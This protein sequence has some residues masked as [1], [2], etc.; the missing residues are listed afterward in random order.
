MVTRHFSA[1]EASLPS[2]FPSKKMATATPPSND[3]LELLEG[4][5]DAEDGEEDILFEVGQ[6][7]PVLVRAHS[8][9]LKKLG[10]DFFRRLLESPMREGREGRVKLPQWEGEVFCMFKRFIYCRKLNVDE[11]KAV[12]ARPDAALGRTLSQL[13]DIAEACLLGDAFR[14]YLARPEM[15]KYVKELFDEAAARRTSD[16]ETVAW[17]RS[18]WVSLGAGPMSRYLKD[19]AVHVEA[20]LIKRLQWGNNVFPLMCFATEH[21]MPLLREKCLQ[22]TKWEVIETTNQQGAETQCLQKFEDEFALERVLRGTQSNGISSR[23]RLRS[24]AECVAVLIDG[25]VDFTWN[26]R[27]LLK[28]CLSERVVS[29]VQG[30]SEDF[31]RDRAR[32]EEVQSKLE[33]ADSKASVLQMKVDAAEG[34]LEAVFTLLAENNPPSGGALGGP[35]DLNNKE[36][37]TKVPEG[38]SGEEKPGAS[39]SGSPRLDVVPG[40]TSSLNL[41]P[42]LASEVAQKALVLREDRKVAKSQKEKIVRL[43]AELTAAK[44]QIQDL[45]RQRAELEQD[46]DRGSL[47]GQQ[48]T[49]EVAL[50]TDQADGSGSRHHVDQRC[51]LARVWPL[52]WRDRGGGGSIGQRGRAENRS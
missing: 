26:R 36:T 31:D 22:K 2:P 48:Q 24:F 52:R 20:M 3:C 8:F 51:W 34:K 12:S 29:V 40:R 6:P 37:A 17:L 41:P 5:A 10:S 23:T 44:A 21:K 38:A 15:E 9:V 13:M 19:Y 28:D 43:E 1:E 50:L 7:N 4:L 14:L 47:G 25:S 16:A 42:K 11:L 18:E 39:V 30:L 45:E 35:S 33:E 27:A 32:L 49:F 46:Q